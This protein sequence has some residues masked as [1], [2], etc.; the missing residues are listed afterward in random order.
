MQTSPVPSHRD[1]ISLRGMMRE[2][3]SK[4]QRPIGL[5]GVQ[6]I[7][8]CLEG[9]RMDAQIDSTASTEVE[10]AEQAMSLS[11]IDMTLVLGA[12]SFLRQRTPGNDIEP[13]PAG[14]QCLVDLI[15]LVVNSRVCYLPVRQRED[16]RAVSPFLRSLPPIVPIPNAAHLS[17]S[18][19]AEKRIVGH[20]WRAVRSL[21]PRWFGQWWKSQV[22]NPAV[23]QYRLNHGS[24]QTFGLADG[25]NASW[26]I[27]NKYVDE[28]IIEGLQPLASWVPREE[29]L[30]NGIRQAGGLA[31][32]QY[33]YAFDVFRRGWQYAEA[34]RVARNASNEPGEAGG[35]LN[36]VYCPH[37]LRQLALK[38]ASDAWVEE[39]R[40]CCWSWGRRIAHAVRTSPTPVGPER[41][42]DWVNSL[43]GSKVDQWI[44]IPARREDGG[45]SEEFKRALRD[46]IERVEEAGI[47]AGIPR[48]IARPFS[49]GLRVAEL[50]IAALLSWHQSGLVLKAMQILAPE[51]V[52]T[53]VAHTPM[54]GAKD[55]VN[56]FRKGTFGHP[57]LI[58]K[59]L[60]ERSRRSAERE[61][62]K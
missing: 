37:P 43:V 60:L 32:Y 52:L 22:S 33:A 14:E 15:D 2:F 62:S 54:E 49:P 44:R 23:V 41:V 59:G 61:S 17:L 12:E 20:F 28:K 30:L 9:E 45:D 27:W 38:A 11:S 47:S 46:L 6:I 19:T 1:E 16:Y 36:I 51:R 8:A 56:C 40:D 42:A 25:G 48:E 24:Q 21:R 26:E 5:D 29:S 31:R 4:T 39:M 57:G 53:R 10:T 13:D 18:I 50:G 35:P 3:S 34:T 58:G 55:V 7:N